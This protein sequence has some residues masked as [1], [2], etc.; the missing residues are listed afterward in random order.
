MLAARH[1]YTQLIWEFFMWD[2]KSYTF[3]NRRGFLVEREE[4]LP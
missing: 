4:V 3:P 2:I 1:R